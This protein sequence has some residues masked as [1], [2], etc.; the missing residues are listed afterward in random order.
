MAKLLL[1]IRVLVADDAPLNI[2][3]MSQVLAEAGAK[4]I[5]A[6]NG[7]QALEKLEEHD[8]DIVLMDLQ[9]P[10]LDGFQATQ[11]IRYSGQ[12]YSQ[13]PII[14]VTAETAPS[15][16]EKSMNAG[17]NDFIS[18]PFVPQVIQ[19]KILALLQASQP[20]PGPVQEEKK[21]AEAPPFD[22]T[23]LKEITNGETEKLMMIVNNLLDNAPV[24]LQ[25]A[26]EAAWLEK[27]PE[28]AADLHKLKGLV[29]L[30]FMP[31]ITDALQVAETGAK[32]EHPD[33]FIVNDK[34]AF[35]SNQLPTLLNLIINDLKK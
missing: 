34:I 16:I 29:G 17:M 9:M 22:L 26:Q 12:R 7:R 21:P 25:K 18:K 3:I 28:A 24:L 6:N 11:V 8:I 30:F 19:Q 5:T 27:W 14:A 35:V 4:V 20:V 1:D 33:G 10:E 23:Y 31:G 32:S 15:E 13:I 2:M